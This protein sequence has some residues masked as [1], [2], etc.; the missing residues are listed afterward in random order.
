MTGATVY[1]LLFCL[2]TLYCLCSLLIS[3]IVSHCI[4]FV[5][6]GCF[7][8]DCLGV[9]LPVYST[10]LFCIFVTEFN[11]VLVGCHP[12]PWCLTVLLSDLTGEI[13]EEPTSVR[14]TE[15]SGRRPFHRT[16]RDFGTSTRGTIW[17]V[18]A[19]THI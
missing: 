18:K 11:F 4:F 10:F 7:V 8:F 12:F 5:F 15:L 6:D 14:W 16:R 19:F 3:L 2:W 13:Q 1:R 9:S 17:K